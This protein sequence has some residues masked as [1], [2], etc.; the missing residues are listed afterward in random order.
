MTPGEI[1]EA[2]VRSTQAALVKHGLSLCEHFALCT[3][4]Y[5]VNVPVERFAMESAKLGFG[6]PRGQP[7]AEEH[8]GAVASCIE[9]GWLRVLSDADFDADG[10]RKD[11]GLGALARDEEFQFY[12]P[13]HV[14][15]TP[16]GYALHLRVLDDIRRGQ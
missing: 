1:D 11:E 4:G 12:R 2:L 7:P 8:V 16:A 15:F 9:K 13:S 3:A 10:C 5:R 6:D 14:D